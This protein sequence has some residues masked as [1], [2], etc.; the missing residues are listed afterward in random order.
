MLKLLLFCHTA[1][2]VVIIIR[3]PATADTAAE[4]GVG[5]VVVE[6]VVVVPEAGV[7]VKV[8]VI[9]FG[10]LLCHR[11]APRKVEL[12]VE[13]PIKRW[14]SVCKE[15]K[16][17]GR[18]KRTKGCSKRRRGRKR[19]KDETRREQEIYRHRFRGHNHV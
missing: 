19:R 2:V 15:K 1:E 8:V 11:A 7:G 16:T 9:L 6:T 17:N 4:A 18:M 3:H 13:N 5:L 12:L 10:L 14:Q